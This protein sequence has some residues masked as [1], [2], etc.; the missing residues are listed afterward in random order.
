MSRANGVFKV[1]RR[2]PENKTTILN[3]ILQDRRHYCTRKQR[4]ED[5]VKGPENKNNWNEQ[6]DQELREPP[7]GEARQTPGDSE[8]H[9]RVP[10]VQAKQMPRLREAAWLT[11]PTAGEALLKAWP[12]QDRMQTKHGSCRMLI[13]QTLNND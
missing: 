9:C 6:E 8:W 12:A 2:K 7:W 10:P 1:Q 11:T 5:N 4:T 3:H 13:V